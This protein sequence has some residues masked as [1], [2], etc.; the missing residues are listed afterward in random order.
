MLT[1]DDLKIGNKVKS[2]NGKEIYTIVDVNAIMQYNYVWRP[3][4]SYISSTGNLKYVRTVE[5]FMLQFDV[6]HP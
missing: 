1:I 2:I 4:I 3:C 5:D 6:V